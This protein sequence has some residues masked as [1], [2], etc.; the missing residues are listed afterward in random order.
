MKGPRRIRISFSEWPFATSPRG[1]V[2]WKLISPRHDDSLVIRCSVR[3]GDDR[4][5]SILV[6][7]LRS[8]Y[9]HAWPTFSDGLKKVAAGKRRC[10]VYRQDESLTLKLLHKEEK[11]WIAL[12]SHHRWI[13]HP[14]QIAPEEMERL[15]DFLLRLGEYYDKCARTYRARREAVEADEAARLKA[16]VARWQAKWEQENGPAENDG[17]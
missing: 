14:V 15:T 3:I 1:T 10:T 4:Y 9:E 12:D 8:S 11:Y 2:K 5:H 7:D 16:A 17:G 6:L 13:L